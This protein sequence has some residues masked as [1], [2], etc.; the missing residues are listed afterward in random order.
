LDI[1]GNANFTAAAGDIV[2]VEAITTSTFRLIPIKDDG[3]AI[4][5][6]PEATLTE[7]KAGVAT[8]KYISP[9]TLRGSVGFSKYFV[10]STAALNTPINE[11]HGLGATPTLVIAMLTCTTAD[12]G[13]SVGD[14]INMPSFWDSSTRGATVGCN[15]TNV[16][17]GYG[18]SGVDLANR[19]A[20][21]A[22][23]SPLTSSSWSVFIVAF[24]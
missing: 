16:F 21:G 4:V 12:Q 18:S 17:I 20:V 10:S 14:Q 5:P 8:G 24:A 2:D 7:A 15:S 23:T 6:V 9:S 11:A 22:G 13:Y 3:T 19:A 1:L